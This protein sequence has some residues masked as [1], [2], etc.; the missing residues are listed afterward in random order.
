MQKPIVNALTSEAQLWKN[1]LSVWHL[2]TVCLLIDSEGAEN[3]V[4]PPG[5]AEATA[6]QHHTERLWD[7]PDT[8]YTTVTYGAY[9]A[10]NRNSNY[11]IKQQ[12]IEQKKPKD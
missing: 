5:S 8:H 10:A 7:T 9:I 12:M 11:R 4:C 1:V 6:P 2:L 3:V